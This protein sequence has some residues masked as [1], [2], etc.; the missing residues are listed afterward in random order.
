[1]MWSKVFPFIIILRE[2]T[3]NKGHKNL[4]KKID[5]SINNKIKY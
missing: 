3:I 5:A 4:A 1:M 2:I